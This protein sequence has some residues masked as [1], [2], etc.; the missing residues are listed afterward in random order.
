MKRILILLSVLLL[1]ASCSSE[2]ED[3]SN[4]FV[5]GMECDYAPFNWT[6]NDSSSGIAI[7]EVDYADGYDVRI[8]MKIADSLGK[9]LVVKKYD[10]DSLIVAL[11]NGDIDAV[12]AGMTDTE[13]RRQ[14]VN[15]TSPYYESKMVII[16]DKDSELANIND[17][18]QL[19]GY[20]VLGQLN[21][22][23]DTCIDQIEGVQH[24]TPM[25]SYPRMVVALQNGEVDA[26]TA[27][28]PVAM[29]ITEANDD[30]CYVTFDSDKGFDAET[31]VSIAIAKD[32][33]ELLNQVEDALSKISEEERNSIMQE[34][35]NDQPTGE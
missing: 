19:S 27:E 22:I 13:E 23:Y 3:D 8:A 18:Q 29:A 25:E 2:K 11:N 1:L 26:L 4:T 9:Q 17:I 33:E 20:K 10:W 14:A 7:N 35:I 5:V 21:T 34:A 12:I 32:N 6:S 31:S 28:L 24:M 30:L 16:V 15:F